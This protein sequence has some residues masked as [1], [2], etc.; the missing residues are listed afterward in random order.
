MEIIPYKLICGYCDVVQF[1]GHR[2]VK[3]ENKTPSEM[4]SKAICD[5]CFESIKKLK[6]EK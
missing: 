1:Q 5:N 2:H 3:E 4:T 6:K